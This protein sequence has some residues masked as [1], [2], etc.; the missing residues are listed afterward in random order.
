MDGYVAA[1]KH[2]KELGAEWK[3]DI[4]EFVQKSHASNKIAQKQY[5]ADWNTNGVKAK[6]FAES[7]I[8]NAQ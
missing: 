5:K 7:A 3:E 6:H 4:T 1:Y 8:E 2:D